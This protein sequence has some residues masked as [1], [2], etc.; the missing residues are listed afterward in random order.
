MIL[1]INHYYDDDDDDDDDYYYYYYFVMAI[2]KRYFPQRGDECGRA[3]NTSNSRTGI[4]GS[5]LARRVVSL[6][7][8]LYSS[9]SLLRGNPA[10]D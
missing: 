7:K 5:I 3:V 1:L 8:E 10:I 9:L 4:W 2:I 6:D